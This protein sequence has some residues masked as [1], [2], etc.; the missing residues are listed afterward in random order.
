MNRFK[1]IG[2]S[3]VAVFAL[4]AVLAASASAKTVLT[5]KTAKGPLAAG[6]EI[7]AES[8]NLEFVTEAG[9]LQCS[10]N[11]LTGTIANN[12]GAKD[13]GEITKESSTGGEPGGACKTTTPLGYTNITSLHLPWSIEYTTKGTSSVKGKKI[14]FE[15]VF[16]LA[17]G[18][19]CTYEAA[20]VASTF[21]TSGVITQTTT[22][23]VFKV[24]KK[25]SN[26]ACPKSGKLSGSFKLFS[27][28]EA[29]SAE[30]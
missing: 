30:L 23:Q 10:S 15:S 6:A 13:K 1:I 4:T 17:G 20:K 5:L 26:A 12:G 19:I 11:I 21:N 8:S 7:V 18:A 3:V 25:V 22:N 27:K 9:A 14:T 2:L 24:N 29:V 16:P 28:G